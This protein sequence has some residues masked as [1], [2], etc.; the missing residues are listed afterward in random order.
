MELRDFEILK[1]ASYEVAELIVKGQSLKFNNPEFFNDPFDCDIN[2]LEFSIEE[3]SEEIKNDLLELKKS[4][5]R[6]IP[7][8]LLAEAYE[9]SQ[10]D[11]IRRSSIC[12][13]SMEYNIPTMWS[14]Y[15]D[16]HSG[17]SLIFDYE[18]EQP[19]EDIPKSSISAFPV[20]YADSDCKPF[21][22]LSSK[23]NGI[24]KLFGTKSTE[25]SYESEFRIMLLNRSGLIRFNKP[26]F[27]GV[28]FGLRVSKRDVESF[29][30]MCNECGYRNLRFYEMKKEGLKSQIKKINTA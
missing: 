12:C 20:N 14:H 24:V 27:S 29:I 13:F 3:V 23:K 16:N 10:K 22:Y 1:Y 6:N 7:N 11:K 15:A 8:E 9:A 18:V 5:P 21:N 28:I 30:S 26:F 19:F 25:W 4:I 2:L 17:V